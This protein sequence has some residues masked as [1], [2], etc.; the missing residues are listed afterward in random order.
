MINNTFCQGNIVCESIINN[1]EYLYI[2][3]LFLVF[4]IVITILIISSI[5]CINKILHGYIRPTVSIRREKE[6]IR[7]VVNYLKIFSTIVIILLWFAVGRLFFLIF[8]IHGE[9]EYIIALVFVVGAI[10]IE[11]LRKLFTFSILMFSHKINFKYYYNFQKGFEG[12]PMDMDFYHVTLK[13]ESGVYC[14]VPNW[15]FLE[16]NK[17]TYVKDRDKFFLEEEDDLDI[18]N[19]V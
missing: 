6:N 8:D 12:F 17:Y 19:K 14:Q 9:T 7:V 2:I 3:I 5:T 4:L 16:K 10:V 11:V 15:H 18:L 1:L 13:N